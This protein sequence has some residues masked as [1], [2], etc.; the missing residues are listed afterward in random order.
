M[1]PVRVL[2]AIL[3]AT[4]SVA[5]GLPPARAEVIRLNTPAVG[6]T[7]DRIGA[8]PDAEREPWIEYLARSQAQMQAD[9]ASLAAELPAGATPPPPPQAVGGSQTHLPLDQ[10]E[11]WYATA[12]ARAV[13]DAVVTFQTP[14]GG[15]S[16]NQDRRI[17]RLPGQ[18]FSNDAETMEQNPANF[19]APADRFWTFVGTLDNNATW[20]EMRFLAKVAAHAPGP[21]GD[22]WRASVIK[23]VQYLLNAQYPNGGWPQIWPLEGGF[24]DSVTFNDNA[25]AQAAMVLRDVSHGEEGFDFVPAELEARAAEATKKAIDVILAAEVRYGDRIMGWPQQVEPLRLV[26]TSARNYEPRSVASGETT[27]IL[28]FLMGEPDPSP[29]M[30]AA[31]RAGAAWLEATQV[32]DKSF[33]MTDDG[34]KL[35]D[36]PGAGP[37]WSRNYDIVT[38]QPIFGDKDQTIHDDVNG[39]SV[40]RRNG[41]SWWIASPQRALDAYTAWSRDNP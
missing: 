40:G 39:I 1:K 3:L 23:G 9:R 31:I 27:D 17:A 25:V 5:V 7:L 24:H 29:E 15:W 22:A 34:R 38:G 36:K 11:A 33:E 2:S 4:T 6:L 8:L 21:Q 32:H 20:S 18:R 28:I 41:Y 30:K 26:P 14:A 13:A 10:P 35:I 37:I 16:K 12:E 19:D